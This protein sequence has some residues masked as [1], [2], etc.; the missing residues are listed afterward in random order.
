VRTGQQAIPAWAAAG[1]DA[2]QLSRVTVGIA[3]FR[4]PW[5]GMAFPGAIWI[6]QDAAGYGW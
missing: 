2:A 4:G 6:D 5:L 1:I 3:D